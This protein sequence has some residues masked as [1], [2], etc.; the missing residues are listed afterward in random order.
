MGAPTMAD[1]ERF[2][3]WSIDTEWTQMKC[4]ASNGLSMFRFHAD[5]RMR[6]VEPR[7]KGCNRSWHAA[8]GGAARFQLQTCCC[9][10]KR[11]R[12]VDLDVPESHG[13]TVVSNSSHGS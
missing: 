6:G 2:R 3:S 9:E 4:L 7:E 12:N 13:H 10:R 1:R 8:V 11:S 5:E